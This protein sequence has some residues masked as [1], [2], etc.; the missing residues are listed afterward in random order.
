MS[1]CHDCD[2]PFEQG[3]ILCPECGSKLAEE[4]GG[5]EMSSGWSSEE[6]T[7]DGQTEKWSI[8]ESTDETAAPDSGWG[9]ASRAADSTANDASEPTYHDSSLLEF[10]LEYPFG[11]GGK[12]MAISSLLWL[13]SFLV[14]PAIF[15]FG[16]A[17]RAGRAAARGDAELPSIDDWGEMGK[18]GLI[19]FGLYLLLSVVLTA[20]LVGFVLVSAA[21]EDPLLV[22]SIGGVGLLLVLV[23]SYVSGAIVP[24]LIG[25]GSLSKTFSDGLVLEFAL[26]VHYLKGML[27]LLLFWIGMSIVANVVA[28]V[29]VL[30]LV[31]IV[32]LLPLAIVQ[33]AYT[34]LFTFALWGYIYNEAAEAGD[35]PPVEPD[36]SLSM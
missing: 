5:V 35:V 27:F 24:V 6:S 32:L 30:T 3:T 20:V 14:V 19:L 8:D 10:V 11:R 18:D 31:G 1:Y 17:Y 16:Y 15:A 28:T 25:T 21:V 23:V 33:A 13:C 9:S 2:E 7:A 29:L 4:G 12:P 26:S 22:V 36:A 34:T